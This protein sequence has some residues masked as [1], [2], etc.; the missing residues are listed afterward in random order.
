MELL[1]STEIQLNAMELLLHQ[2]RDVSIIPVQIFK[3][4]GKA[5]SIRCYGPGIVAFKHQWSKTAQENSKKYHLHIYKER[6]PQFIEGHDEASCRAGARYRIADLP[7]LWYFKDVWR[8]L[9]QVDL[10]EGVEEESSSFGQESDEK[11]LEDKKK[12]MKKVAERLARQRTEVDVAAR[13]RGDTVGPYFSIHKHQ[14]ESSES[15][16]AL[17]GERKLIHESEKVLKES[18]DVE[19]RGRNV[20]PQGHNPVAAPALAFSNQGMWT[21]SKTGDGACD[22]VSGIL[23]PAGYYNKW[24]RQTSISQTLAE[25]SFPAI[26]R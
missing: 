14:A 4:T 18:L 8:W 3:E 20:L 13:S 25:Y 12:E 7:D 24:R 22:G 6:A 5:P 16:T 1:R 26:A 15:E 9:E 23:T 10:R 17:G 19:T 21:N 2:Q 11:D